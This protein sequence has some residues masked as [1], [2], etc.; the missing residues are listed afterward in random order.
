MNIL[1]DGYNGLPEEVRIGGTLYPINSDFHYSIMFE[2]L[3]Q[4]NDVPDNQKLAKAA[5]IYFPII[6]HDAEEAVDK[7]LWFY[8]CGREESA[9]KKRINARRSKTRAYSFD[10]DDEYIYAAFMAQ[11][12]I[13]LTETSMHWW[14]FRALFRSLTDAN[15][16]VKIQEYRT[17]EIKEGM[18]KDQKDF[19]KRMKR[20]HALPVSKTEDK[21]HADIEYALMHGGDL[22]GLL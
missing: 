13:D 12:G 10:Y 4:D 16:F 2:I 9:Q 1:L 3:M 21:R 22:T 19:Y 15:E 20:I 8:T 18:S 5:R 17:V 11:Y 14:K 6:P 7:M